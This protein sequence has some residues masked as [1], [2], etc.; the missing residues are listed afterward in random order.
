MASDLEQLLRLGVISPDVFAKY[1]GHLTQAAQ[2]QAP[3]GQQATPPA[4][5][6]PAAMA[7]GPVAQAQ[8]PVMYTHP[9]Q[10]TGPPAPR[11]QLP[12]EGPSPEEMRRNPNLPPALIRR[13]SDAGLIA[14][15]GPQG[16]GPG[17]F[18]LLQPNDP[19]FQMTPEQIQQRRQ[20]QDQYQQQTPIGNLGIRG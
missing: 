11:P 2:A 3:A 14:S 19:R 8:P 1:M 10:N 15:Q 13:L 18:P 4:S 9:G 17:S 5:T 16:P 20:M 6:G 12:P 7:P